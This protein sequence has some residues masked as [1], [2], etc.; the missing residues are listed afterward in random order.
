[1]GEVTRGNFS[2]SENGPGESEESMPV[3]EIL[4]VDIPKV[5][6]E[7]E[8]KLG[9]KD[10]YMKNINPDNM[11]DDMED[12]DPKAWKRAVK[13]AGQ[14]LSFVVSLEEKSKSSTKN[15]SPKTFSN[16]Y[17]MD[18]ILDSKQED[19]KEDTAHYKA[20]AEQIKLMAKNA[21]E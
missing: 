11:P 19:W 15:S 1:M 18:M 17:V 9:T 6:V 7:K 13:K 8:R 4:S 10:F 2:N 20:A 16:Q 3:P 21:A 14:V 12:V 5:K